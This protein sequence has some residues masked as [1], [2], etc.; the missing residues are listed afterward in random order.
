MSQSQSPLIAVAL[1]ALLPSAAG[2]QDVTLTVT[3][4]KETFQVA[5]ALACMECHCE[6]TE[7]PARLQ[8]VTAW[9]TRKLGLAGGIMPQVTIQE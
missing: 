7:E 8:Q 6:A 2:A 3:M 4:P 5:L 1:L 9:I